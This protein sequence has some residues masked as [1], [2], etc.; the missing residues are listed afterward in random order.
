MLA[1]EKKARTKFVEFYDEACSSKEQLSDAQAPTIKKSQFEFLKWLKLEKTLFKLEYLKTMMDTD[2]ALRKW[3]FLWL[4]PNALD[5][6]YQCI[7]PTLQILQQLDSNVRSRLPHMKPL[8]RPWEGK[9]KLPKK[10]T[11][12]EEQKHPVEGPMEK[13]QRMT[14]STWEALNVIA[15]AMDTTANTTIDCSKLTDYW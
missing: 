4:R 12:K 13:G 8:I 1:Q 5:W 14:M 6:K 7:P 11:R 10:R 15:I 2:K 9:Q 3:N